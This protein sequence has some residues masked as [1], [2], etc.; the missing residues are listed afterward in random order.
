MILQPGAQAL[1]FDVDADQL[2]DRVLDVADV[3]DLAAQVE[4]QQLEAIAHAAAFEILQT[5][6]GLRDVS[7]NLER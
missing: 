6:S 2:D 7:P 3:V 1:Q 4:V 5:R